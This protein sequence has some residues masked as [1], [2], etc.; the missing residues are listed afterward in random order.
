MRLLKKAKDIAFEL[1]HFIAD[2]IDSLTEFEKKSSVLPERI[3]KTGS[4][5][6]PLTEIVICTSISGGADYVNEMPRRLTLHRKLANGKE[7]AAVYLQEADN[8]KR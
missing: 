4:P 2:I 6:E 3:S 8:E 5:D 1:C 7:H